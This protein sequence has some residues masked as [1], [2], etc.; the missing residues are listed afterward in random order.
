M[1]EAERESTSWSTSSWRRQLSIELLQSTWI[2]SGKD[3]RSPSAQVLLLVML[4]VGERERECVY[5]PTLV[6]VE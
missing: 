6:V 2:F 4:V 1:I 5:E 3:E